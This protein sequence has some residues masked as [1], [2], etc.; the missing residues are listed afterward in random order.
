LPEIQRWYNKALSYE[1]TA[2][3]DDKLKAQ[4][5]RYQI[6]P[7][8]LDFLTPLAPESPLTEWLRAFGPSPY[9]AT[10]RCGSPSPLGLDLKLTHGA[11]LFFI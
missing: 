4:G 8:K 1:G 5:S 2:I 7:H 3:S 10:L 11:D 6:G 9:A